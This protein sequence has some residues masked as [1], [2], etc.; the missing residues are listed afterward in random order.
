ALADSAPEPTV[1]RPEAPAGELDAAAVRQVW[2][3]LLTIVKRRRRITEALLVN[4]TA[5]SV[6]G[7]LLRL[8][9]GSPVLMRMLSDPANTEVLQIS[10]KDLLGVDW[11]IETVV[12]TPTLPDAGKP[13]PDPRDDE[14]V[15]EPVADARPRD[16]EADAIS[17]VQDQLG[18]KRID[19]D[20]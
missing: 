2:P 7:G 14:P 4:A 18:A 6:E 15:A 1:H 16:P 9:I 11:R 20:S 8:G 19:P 12:Q 5:L 3:E 17:L 13:E 10:L